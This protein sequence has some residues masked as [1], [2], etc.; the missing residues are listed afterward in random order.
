MFSRKSSAFSTVMHTHTH[1][2]TPTHTHAHHTHTRSLSLFPCYCLPLAP[3]TPSALS[4]PGALERISG[5][6]A[7]TPTPQQTLS[8]AHSHRSDLAALIAACARC[9]TRALSAAMNVSVCIC[10]CMYMCEYTLSLPLSLS[11][12]FTHTHTHTHSLTHTH[13]HTAWDTR[14]VSWNVSLYPEQN[15]VDINGGHKVGVHLYVCVDVYRIYHMYHMHHIHH[16]YHMYH[17]WRTFVLS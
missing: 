17:T 7:R 14:F 16:V 10:V 15:S 2:H 1:T 9:G 6:H 5:P 12:S 13:T 11:L 3:K 8:F 4:V